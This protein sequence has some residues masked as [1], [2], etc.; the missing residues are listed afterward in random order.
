[1]DGIYTIQTVKNHS[2]KAYCDMTHNGGGWMLLVASA[3]N[4]WDPKKVLANNMD[5][6]DLFS[7]Y[8]ILKYAND[9]KD[10]YMIKQDYFEYRLEAEKRGNLE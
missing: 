7:D 2:I 6:P 10:Y 5:K 9:L 4:K 1:M 3:T 8:S